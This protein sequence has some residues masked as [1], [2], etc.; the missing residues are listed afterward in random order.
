MLFF[1]FPYPSHPL[2]MLNM[3]HNE[4]WHVY[5]SLFYKCSWDVFAPASTVLTC[6]HATNSIT[7]V[8]YSSGCVMLP[9]E[10]ICFC[11]LFVTQFVSKTCWR[12]SMHPSQLMRDSPRRVQWLSAQLGGDRTEFPTDFSAAASVCIVLLQGEISG[13]SPRKGNCRRKSGKMYECMIL[14]VPGILQLTPL[15]HSELCSGLLRKR[16]EIQAGRWC[17]VYTETS[18]VQFPR[19]ATDNTQLCWKVLLT[20]TLVPHFASSGI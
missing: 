12:F 2:F 7:E 17:C 1:Y 6:Q 15:F 18:H 14:L 3:P 11:P 13:L 20:R 9:H 4:P 10:T 5:S 16:L 8:I 19:G